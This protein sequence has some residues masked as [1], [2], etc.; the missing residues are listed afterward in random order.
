MLRKH[1]MFIYCKT[2]N[3]EIGYVIAEYLEKK[4]GFR[5]GNWRIEVL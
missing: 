4:I 2:H 1:C 5:H 3:H